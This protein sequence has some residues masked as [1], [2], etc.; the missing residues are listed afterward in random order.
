[1]KRILAGL[2]A[3]LLAAAFLPQVSLA[4]EV[5]VGTISYD[6]D[7]VSG[8]AP[9][10]NSFDW[11]NLT[12]GFLLPGVVDSVVLN[13]ALTVNGSL[14]A[15]LTDQGPGV[16]DLL[17]I[18]ES[19]PIT[20]AGLTLDLVAIPITFFDGGTTTQHVLSATSVVVNLPLFNGSLVPCDG[21]GA[22]C[23]SGAVFADVAPPIATPEPATMFLLS[24]GVAFTLLRRF[25]SWKAYVS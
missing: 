4:D 11:T 5:Q 15:S 22:P 19:T 8:V 14:S 2:A 13:V 10:F 1:M 9:G 24:V 12:G 16:Y 20:S 3:I 25:F 21:T 7:V 17:D 18:S 23:S 6:T